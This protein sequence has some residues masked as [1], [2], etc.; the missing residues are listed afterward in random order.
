M[1]SVLVARDVLRITNLQYNGQT[2]W[3]SVKNGNQNDRIR[4]GNNRLISCINFHFLTILCEKLGGCFRLRS[5]PFLIRLFRFPFST[6]TQT[7]TTKIF[8][9]IYVWSN[10]YLQFLPT[11]F[12]FV[13]FIISPEPAGV[14]PGELIPPGYLHPCTFPGR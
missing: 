14:S 13:Q 11:C 3:V 7:D 12:N 1:Y 10:F 2:D 8:T 5:F 6:E 4:N 9:T